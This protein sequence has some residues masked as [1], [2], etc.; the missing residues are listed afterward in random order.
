MICAPQPVSSSGD[1]DL[2]VPRVPTGIKIGVSI[3]PRAVSSLP[4]RA[5]LS[6]DCF[7]TSNFIVKIQRQIHSRAKPQRRKESQE[8]YL[9]ALSCE[10]FPKR[11]CFY[12][13]LGSTGEAGNELCFPTSL[14]CSF[15][16]H[17]RRTSWRL[18]VLA[19]VNVFDLGFPAKPDTLQLS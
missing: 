8:Y 16:P 11:I 5:L 6:F 14:D 13:F 19:R 1:R 7:K 18:G 4:V 15:D 3:V 2:T 9:G 10:K 17:L 12:Q